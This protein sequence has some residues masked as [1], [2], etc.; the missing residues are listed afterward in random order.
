MRMEGFIGESQRVGNR[1]IMIGFAGFLGGGMKAMYTGSPV[2]RAAG[3][4]GASC[5]LVGTTC[6]GSESL[7]Y[8]ALQRFNQATG[9]KEEHKR[10]LLISHSLGGMCG[11]GIIGGLFQGRV[12]RGML[13]LTPL[14][15]GVGLAEIKF[16]ELR[17][18]RMKELLLD[19]MEKDKKK[20]QTQDTFSR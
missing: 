14:M 18:E 12:V 2:L 19:S 1:M 11:G 5:C 6:F 15:L 3:F 9:A 13:L 8:V 17:D 16:L 4:S 10:D 20:K 7:A